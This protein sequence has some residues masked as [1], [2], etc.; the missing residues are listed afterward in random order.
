L[1]RGRM[2]L[3]A[4]AHDLACDALSHAIALQ[5]SNEAAFEP[6][7]RASAGAGRVDA[8]V[9]QLQAIVDADAANIPARAA[10]ARLLMARGDAPGAIRAIES[11]GAHDID[12]VRL[13][14]E[15]ASIY[16]D[17][18]DADRLAPIVARLQRD[19]PEAPDTH[20]FAAS[21][22]FLQGDLDRAL[23]LARALVARHPDHA[24]AQNLIGAALATQGQV[25]AARA[26]FANSI[27]ADPRDSGTYVNAGSLELEHGR[28][29]DAR[30]H[31]AIALA[32]DLTSDAARRGLAAA[33]EALRRP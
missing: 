24:R 29:A 16:A 10:F 7:A 28:P 13:Q 22:A 12:D 14:R 1:S 33:N 26:A 11:A 21:Q 27:A 3:R 23:Q 19:A 18:G 30:R 5:P 2:L 8:A 9:A 31:F 20:Y 25:D 15:L 4:Q 17:L 6:F 32:M